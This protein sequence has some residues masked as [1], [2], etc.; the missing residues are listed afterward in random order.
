M[1]QKHPV[2]V[3]MQKQDPK[4]LQDEKTQKM[5]FVLCR[6]IQDVCSYTALMRTCLMH[7]LIQT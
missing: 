1:L 2:I 7:L 4:E 5:K 6:N 3:Q